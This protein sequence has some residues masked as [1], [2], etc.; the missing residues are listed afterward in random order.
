MPGIV[1][2]GEFPRPCGDAAS[3]QQVAEAAFQPRTAIGASSPG[4]VPYQRS[5]I[6]NRKVAA[7]SR[8]QAMID[9]RGNGSVDGEQ[10]RFIKPGCANEQR[11]FLPAV[12]RD[13]Q[14]QQL[15]TANSGGEQ[16]HGCEANDL[17]THNRRG[18][19]LQTVRRSDHPGSF[20]FGKDIGLDALMVCGKRTNV[21]DEA[22][23]LGPATIQT[24]AAHIEHAN[25]SNPRGRVLES[26]APCLKRNGVQIGVLCSVAAQKAVQ[27][28]QSAGR[29]VEPSSQRALQID[30]ARKDRRKRRREHGRERRSASFHCNSSLPLF[31]PG[32]GRATSRKS[33]VANRRYMEVLSAVRCPRMSPIVFSEVPFFKRCAA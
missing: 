8:L 25:S 9:L 23:R 22:L 13:S 12:I 29:S 24:K 19:P 3:S 31:I 11:R 7:D 1:N 32:T 16:E 2:A 28:L 20:G 14:G 18:A 33:S 17:R 15:A 30:I 4:V 26:A 27:R 10:S 6:G 21:G 5:I